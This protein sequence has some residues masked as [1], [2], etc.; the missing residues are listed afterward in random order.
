MHPD[1]IRLLRDWFSARTVVDCPDN[2]ED[3]NALWWLQKVLWVKK[4][5]G[6]HVT[7]GVESSPGN[8]GLQGPSPETA[9]LIIADR[10]GW[11][12][13]YSH[14]AV[15]QAAKNWHYW[16][17][18]FVWGDRADHMT[19]LNGVPGLTGHREF[20]PEASPTLHMDAVSDGEKILLF[21]PC[22][23]GPMG[24]FDPGTHGITPSPG[25][26]LRA[27]GKNLWVRGEVVP[28]GKWQNN[29]IEP[30][31]FEGGWFLLH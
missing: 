17:V 10:T 11:P 25:I 12:F 5:Q 20:F 29:R 4:G 27:T 18:R 19:W 28:D 2:W 16:D 26:I 3:R 13:V 7:E 1:R 9:A 6:F 22:L 30:V 23:L 8:D 15:Y 21:H 31:S 24:I 14:R